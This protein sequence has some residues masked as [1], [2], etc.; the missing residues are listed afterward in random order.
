MP[1][2]H[3]ITR[4]LTAALLAPAVLAAQRGATRANLV[5]GPVDSSYFGVQWRNIGPN[6]AG[7]MVAVAGSTTRPK[8]YYFGTTGGGVWK[9]SDGGTTVVPVT[10]KYFGGTIG[11]IAVSETNPDIVYVGGGET[12]IRG[13]V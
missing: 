1:S 10:D 8:E 12:P 2:S 11:A 5:A 6:S 13:D 4:V 9:T 7:R 3:T